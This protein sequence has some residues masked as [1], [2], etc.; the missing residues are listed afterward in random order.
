MCSLSPLWAGMDRS[1]FYLVTLVGLT[2][3]AFAAN[4]LLARLALADGAIDAGSYTLLRL[5]SGAFVLFVLVSIPRKTGLRQILRQGH[6]LSALSLFI[7][8]AGFSYAYLALDTGMGALILFAMVQTTM[9]G[10]AIFKGDRP[11]A[12]EWIGLITAFGAF[13]WLVSPGIQAPDPLGT[14]LMA[15]AGVAWGVYSL[16][17]RAS[18]DPLATTA[19]NFALSVPAALLLLV[20]SIAEISTSGTGVLLAIMSGGLTSGLGYALW[21][22][23]LPHISSTQ[24]AIVQLT[25]PVIAAAAGVVFIS[26][27]LTWKFMIASV[28]I[29]GGVALAI[30]GKS[31][32][33]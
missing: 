29:L 22:R 31:R 30:V 32:R 2:M 19:G 23:V 24:G 15:A 33:A 11:M 10:W 13:F 28:L 1:G 8:A 20:F 6:W 5:I 14:A 16:R 25:V 4:S 7:Y 27:P 17:G 12:L 9:V 3:T 26:E 21:Y 18:T